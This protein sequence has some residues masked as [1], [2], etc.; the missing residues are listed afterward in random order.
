MPVIEDVITEDLLTFTFPQGAMSSK[1]DEWSHYRNQ[2]NNAFGGAK[3]VDVVYA[4]DVVA[5]LIEIKDYRIHPRTKTIDLAEEVAT[6]VRDS[7]AGLVSA[8]LCANDADEKTVAKA[9]L[10]KQRIRV[11]LHLEIPVKTSRLRNQAIE[12]DKVLMKL[13]PLVKSI[14]PHPRVVDQTTL[15]A[16]MSWTVAG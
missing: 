7:L 3:A 14:D 2:F 5:W 8:R 4:A 15:T 9:L 16:E 10:K 12:L 1:Y 6:K 11:V 13:K